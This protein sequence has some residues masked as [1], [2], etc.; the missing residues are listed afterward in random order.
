MPRSAPRTSAISDMFVWKCAW[1]GGRTRRG[2]SQPDSAQEFSYPIVEPLLGPYRTMYVRARRLQ[3]PLL[4][5]GL[6]APPAVR[7]YPLFRRKS[8]N[9]TS[10]RSPQLRPAR[11]GAR[12]AREVGDPP[13]NRHWADPSDWEMHW[14]GR[15]GLRGRGRGRKPDPLGVNHRRGIPSLALRQINSRCFRG[16]LMSGKETL[17]SKS[18]YS[19]VI[20]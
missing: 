3:M 17:Q 8:S 15:P 18:R 11:A 13:A 10:G 16:L 2:G 4:A 12:L 6:Y 20:Q 19:G 9:R 14:Q 5:F 1:G 7:A